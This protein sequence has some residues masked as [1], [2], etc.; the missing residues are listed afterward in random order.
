MQRSANLFLRG[1]LYR[2][3]I[4]DF[5]IEE[6]EREKINNV[7]VKQDGASCYYSLFVEEFLNN[8]LPDV[9]CIV[10]FLVTSSPDLTPLD[11]FFGASLR[12]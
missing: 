8:R 9:R 4:P 11:C 5:L 6:I 1:D 3:L 2:Q 10:L 7:T 12:T